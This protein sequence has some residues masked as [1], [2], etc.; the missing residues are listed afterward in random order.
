M[1]QM[2]IRC[3]F[4]L[5]AVI[6]A[7]M[8]VTG[9]VTLPDVL[10]KNS[11]QEQLKYIEE[12]TRIYEDY[13][14]IREDMFQKIKRNVSDTLSE[15]NNKIIL[16]NKTKSFLSLT[17][18]SLRTNMVSTKN[19]L[20]E[21]IRTKNSINVVGLEINKM[22]Y[23]KIMWTILAGLITLLLI[24][25]LVFKRNLSTVFN[26]KKELQEIKDEFDAYRKT[27]REAREKLTMDHFNEIKRLKGV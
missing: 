4:I 15:I 24:G 23:N 3:L 22:T 6:I 19:R 20:E 12:H 17:I 25:F 16:L 7:V 14:A 9:Q 5:T 13:R 21:I 11:L 27:S 18:D 2:Q 26:T 8:K 10:I 1:K